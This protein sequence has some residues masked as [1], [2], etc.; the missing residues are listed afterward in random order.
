MK[1]IPKYLLAV[2]FLGTASALFFRNFSEAVWI[3]WA[4]FLIAAFVVWRFRAMISHQ[5]FSRFFLVFAFMFLISVPLIG[6]KETESYEKRALAEFPEFRLGNPWKFFFGFTDWFND[7]F[8]FRNEAVQSISKFRLH[9]FKISTMPRIVEWG[10]GNW[11]FTSRKEYVDD[12]SI[13]FTEAQLDTVEKNLE[14][15]TKFFDTKGIKF[16][17]AMIPVKE[18][19]Y[20]EYM[21][22]LL[23][24]RMRHSKQAQIYERIAS[25]PN[26]RSVDVKDVLIEGKKEHPTYYT[27]DTHWNHYGSFLA[28]RKIIERIRKDFP[29]IKPSELG[30]YEMSSSVTDAGD[31][32]ILM[33]FRDEFHFE[34]IHLTHKSGLK[35]IS[36]DGDTA[37]VGEHKKYQAYTMSG[38]NNNLRLALI[39]DSFSE[40]LK[41]FICRDFSRSD[42]VWTPR[43]PV[44]EILAAKPDIVLQEML[45]MFVMNTLVL[46]E[47]IKKDST[48]MKENFP[49]W[50]IK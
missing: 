37:E 38:V 29:E 7:R 24:H 44:K 22:E 21:S 8:A 40:Y 31:L 17:F 42:L 26:I 1:H 9:T 16:Y 41:L 25:N 43:L 27:T 18:R 20:P 39:R 12:T 46:P 34:H 49:G 15:I 14:I 13:P 5:P 35:L 32:Q 47:E 23:R 3:W 33:G 10:E 4:S 2:L 11:L 28:Y 36:T 48:F 19:I 6:K 30:D 45:E 50:V